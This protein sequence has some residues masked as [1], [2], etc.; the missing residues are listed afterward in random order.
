MTKK[1]CILGTA[2]TLKEAPFNDNTLEFWALG[3]MFGSVPMQKIS[4]WFEIHSRE[5]NDKHIIRYTNQ[6]QI[7]ALKSLTIPVYMQEHYRD[8]PASIPYPLEEM[9]NQYRDLFRSTV[10]Y[11]MAL[12]IHENY[13]EIHMYGINMS[14][15]GEYASQRPSLYYWL[16]QAEGRGIKIFL[17]AGCDLLKAYFRYGY[18]EEKENDLLIKARSKS[19]ELAKNAAEFQKNY[20]L[21][22]GAKDT[23]DFIQRELG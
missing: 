17:P 2:S 23:W 1:V 10:D 19:A 3:D 4:R 5:E 7:E 6:S 9:A 16:G 22:L 18:D 8:I 12:A 14:T 13:D 11:M 21:S 15:D 20:Y